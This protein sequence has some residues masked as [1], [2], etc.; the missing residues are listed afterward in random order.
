VFSLKQDLLVL[1]WAQHICSKLHHALLI[2]C[3]AWVCIYTSLLC[4]FVEC[5]V[6]LLRC[7]PIHHN[8]QE[9]LEKPEHCYPL[10]PTILALAAL[11]LGIDGVIWIMPHRFVWKLQLRLA[12]KIA[13]TSIFTLG[14]LCDD[15]DSSRMPEILADSS[16]QQHRRRHITYRSP[17]GSLLGQRY[18]IPCRSCD[19]LGHDATQHRDHVG[20]LS[21]DTTSLQD[22]CWETS[23]QIDHQNHDV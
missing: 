19:H 15:I 9:H 12:H 18:H 8:W 6:V 1:R 3:L 4:L 23:Y 5:I 20:M 14:L 21:A 2:P 17:R 16:L 22:M 10:K 11:G 7:R 13:I